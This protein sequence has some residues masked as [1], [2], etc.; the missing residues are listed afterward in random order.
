[1]KFNRIL[2]SSRLNIK[3]PTSQGGE[4]SE[5]EERSDESARNCAQKEYQ[6]LFSL[7]YSAN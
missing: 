3:I 1:M 5:H 7:T 2:Y 4:R 6:L